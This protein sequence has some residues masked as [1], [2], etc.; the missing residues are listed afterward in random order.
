MFCLLVSLCTTRLQCLQRPEEHIGPSRTGVTDGCGRHVDAGELNAGPLQS[1]QMFS[2]T[3]PSLQ[4]HVQD[5]LMGLENWE[6]VM[7][8]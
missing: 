6:M 5:F 3:E 2:A 7:F 8:T 1:Q 4:P